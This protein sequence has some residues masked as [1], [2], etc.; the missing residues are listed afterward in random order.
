[1]DLT[2]LD[3]DFIDNELNGHGYLLNHGRYDDAGNRVELRQ[4][5]SCP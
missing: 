2:T 1:M 5:L 4:L 3:V